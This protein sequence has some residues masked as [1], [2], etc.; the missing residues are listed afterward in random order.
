[1]ESGT[2]SAKLWGVQDPN[3][4]KFGM[5]LAGWSSSTGDADWAIRP[6]YATE[7]WVPTAYNVSY[8][9]NKEVDGYINAALATA[10]PAKR[11]EAYKYA[12]KLVWE[13]APVIFLGAPDSLVGKVSSL[14]GV[15]MLAD[16]SLAF[17]AAEFKN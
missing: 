6:L 17:T 15:Y 12:Q 7:S 3:K 9:S 1:M 10:D 11:S 2:R 14:E 5:Y 16:R 13:D 8:Y 4:A